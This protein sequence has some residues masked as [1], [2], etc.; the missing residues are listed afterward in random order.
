MKI[1][2]GV[3]IHIA[4]VG[5]EILTGPQESDA[6]PRLI[7]GPTLTAPTGRRERMTTIT[8]LG[9]LV[10]AMDSGDINLAVTCT[11]TGFVLNVQ[12]TRSKEYNEAVLANIFWHPKIMV[13]VA[14]TQP[15]VT[16]SVVWSI[17]TTTGASLGHAR[18]PPY[19]ELQYPITVT[20]LIRN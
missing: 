12:M 19:P 13:A 9:P 17:R 11:F 18:T 14:A 6:R 2:G 10:G 15:E 20:T 3:T 16:M 8:A 1:C 7:V 4:D 5:T